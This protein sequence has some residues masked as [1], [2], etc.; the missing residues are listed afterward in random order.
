[1]EKIYKEYWFSYMKKCVLITIPIFIFLMIGFQFF[2]YDF[3]TALCFMGII[4]IVTFMGCVGAYF[5]VNEIKFFKNSI[6]ADGETVKYSQFQ[7]VYVES[8]RKLRLRTSSERDVLEILLPKS[9]FKEDIVAL[10]KEFEAHG[11]KVVFNKYLFN[12]FDMNADLASMPKHKLF[13]PNLLVVVFLCFPFLGIHT[14]IKENQYTSFYD[15]GTLK[16]KAPLRNGVRQGVAVAYYQNG[17]VM[18]EVEYKKGN[19]DGI[20]K[21]YNEQ[22]QLIFDGSQNENGRSGTHLLYDENGKIQMESE[23]K[24]NVITGAFRYYKPDGKIETDIS[25]NPDND[26]FTVKSYRDNGVLW[27][28]FEVKDGIRDGKFVWYWENGKVHIDGTIKE[29]HVIGIEYDENGNKIG[30][31]SMDVE[32]ME[33]LKNVFGK[34]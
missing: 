18:S 34:K 2:D 9:F 12:I 27:N 13:W 4:F 8:E 3:S 15:D 19:P 17:K 29:N 7:E 24:N 23:E 21:L 5:K 10:L 16:E 33:G 30:E 22:G 32:P 20:V 14:D 31:V 1:M 11:K 25:K 6:S 28:Y 26:K